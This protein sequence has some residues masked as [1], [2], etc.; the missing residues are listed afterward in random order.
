MTTGRVRKR[1]DKWGYII[2][3]PYDPIRGNYPTIRKS[4][5]QSKAQAFEAMTQAIAKIDSG[6]VA[7]AAMKVEEYLNEWLIQIQDKVAPRTLETYEDT[8][9][10]ISFYIGDLR[11]DKL[12]HFAIESMY[13]KLK[14]KELAPSTIHRVHRVLR[15]ALNRAV[16]RGIIKETP[17]KRVD[18]PSGKIER[19]N[20]LSVEQAHQLLN[21]L[22]DHRYLSYL[23]ATIALHTG[24]RR[25]EICGLQWRDIDWERKIIRI[26]RSRQRRKGKD[27]IGNPKTV[28]SI[29]PIPVDDDLIE[30]LHVWYGAFPLP[31]IDMQFILAHPD[32]K[33]I[34][35]MTLSRDV[36]IAVNK[37]NL[38]K[39]SFHDLRHTHAT[40]LLQANVPLKIVSERL[41]HASI[42]MTADT[43][44]HVTETMQQDATQRISDLLRTKKS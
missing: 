5:F 41:G 44:S 33:P 9:K 23:G 11:L 43:Y 19:R 24:M 20:V 25:G 6:E 38:P 37:L 31:P 17:M 14:A 32:G 42:A 39:V 18:S 34:D 15:A 16:K 27:F 3:M 29:R 8:K 30:L 2:N 35:P 21:W 26:T 12:D 1:G 4:G 40:L 7:F 22:K 10:I 28:G 13:E 36:R